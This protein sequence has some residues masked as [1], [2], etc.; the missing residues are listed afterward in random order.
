LSSSLQLPTATR[1][2]LGDVVAASLRDA[3]LKGAI[4]PHERIIE[5]VVA[6]SMRVSRGP[7]RDALASLEKEGLL[8][9]V[10]NRGAKVLE[11][12]ARDEAEINSL[13]A[14][15]EGLAVRL[16]IERGPA[17][18]VEKLHANQ[19]RMA[20]CANPAEMAEADLEFH[21]IILRAANHSRLLEAWLQL[22]SQV[23]L[24]M[25]RHLHRANAQTVTLGGHQALIDA[26]AA[27]D[28]LKAQS[29]T[30]QLLMNCQPVV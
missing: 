8:Q 25:F 9:R 2:S 23:R 6:E 28:R 26:I 3:I 27:C 30:E 14:A 15:L 17:D 21:E 11:F 16:V 4:R 19:Q 12:E 1:Q 7:V 20:R 22:K 29:L 18:C 24:L 10:S 13:R 5:T